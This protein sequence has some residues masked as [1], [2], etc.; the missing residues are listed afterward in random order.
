MCSTFIIFSNSSIV[1]PGFKLLKL[2]AL[3]LAA[4]SLLCALDGSCELVGVYGSYEVV[5]VYGSYEVVGVYGS[6]E[7]ALFS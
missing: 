7:V 3:T 2:H 1:L 4:R 6:Y 5:G